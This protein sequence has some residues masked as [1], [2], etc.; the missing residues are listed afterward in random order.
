MSLQHTDRACVVKLEWQLSKQTCYQMS[1]TCHCYPGCLSSSWICGTT[2]TPHW[3]LRRPVCFCNFSAAAH[4]RI[5]HFYKMRIDYR[6]FIVAQVTLGCFE[7]LTSSFS[8]LQLFSCSFKSCRSFTACRVAMVRFLSV[9][10]LLFL[11]VS[12]QCFLFAM[13]VFLSLMFW[14]AW[15]S[16]WMY[17]RNKTGIQILECAVERVHVLLAFIVQRFISVETACQG[18]IFYQSTLLHLSISLLHLL[19]GVFPLVDE[20]LCLLVGLLQILCRF[21]QSN[22]WGKEKKRKV[23]SLQQFVV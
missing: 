14:L 3:R 11:W 20:L 21:V 23:Y 16:C 7:M 19:D 4:T 8:L 22:L 9:S 2:Q 6:H 10:L 13:V 15:A 18:R 1:L 5:N 17:E 12:S